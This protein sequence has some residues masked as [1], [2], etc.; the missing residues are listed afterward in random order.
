VLE[1]YL[2]NFGNYDQDNWYQMLPLAQYAYNNSKT[3]AHKPTP[4]FAN[5]GF[6]PQTEW[7]KE[8][9]AQNPVATMYTHWM[10][11]VQENA[12]TTLEQT[13]EA[14]KKCYDR[15][16]TPQP[17]LETGD[18]VML[19]AKNLKS[20]RLLQSSSLWVILAVSN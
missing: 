10:K 14:M 9:E 5:Y 18:L 19:N 13:R 11:R 3:G 15:K 17:D 6:H 1:G 12:R 8:R 16:A 4:F 2:P 20:K 7:M